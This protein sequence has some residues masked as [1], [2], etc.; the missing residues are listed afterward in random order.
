VTDPFPGSSASEPAAPAATA[1]PTPGKGKD[2][3]PRK[4]LAK[5]LGPVGAN[6]VEWGIVV[7]G[8]VA[9]ALLVKAFVLQAFFIPSL[10]MATTLE[11]GDRVLVN[12]LAYTFGDVSRGDIVVFERP[13]SQTPNEIPDLI[14]RVIGLPGDSLVIKDDRVYVNGTPLEEPYLDPGTVT[15]TATTPRKCTDVEPCLVPEDEV[16]VMGDNRPD[17]QD[18][19]YFGTI[20]ED[21]I[22]G[23]AFVRVWPLDRLGG[24]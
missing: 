24:L 16:W 7:V 6:L 2:G 9:L 22:V 14:K 11:K 4:G 19:R 10:S 12:K 20:P 17:S 8:A 13:P 1:T 15:S 3:R 21:S 18:S 5:W 23:K